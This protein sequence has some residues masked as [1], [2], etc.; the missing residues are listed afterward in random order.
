MRG[1]EA[2]Q[3]QVSTGVRNGE[4]VEIT[5]GLAAGDRLIISDT[6]EL[7]RMQTFQITQ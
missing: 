5:G 4:Y 3:T 6:E 1:G 7:E 2:R